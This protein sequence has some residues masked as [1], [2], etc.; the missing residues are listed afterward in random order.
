MKKV[1]AKLFKIQCFFAL[2]ATVMSAVGF[3]FAEAVSVASGAS[4]A[5]VATL[6]IMVLF[7]RV[8]EV[9]PARLFYRLMLISEGFKWAVV[10]VLTVLLLPYVMPLG[11]VVGFFITY[12]GYFWM[13]FFYRG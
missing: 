13:T 6:F 4:V 5:L 2:I 9:I 3:G 8:P 10:S 7:A 1:L 12:S 11:L